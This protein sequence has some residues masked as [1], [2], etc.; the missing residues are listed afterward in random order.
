MNRFNMNN[1]DYRLHDYNFIH[2]KSGR[3]ND[4]LKNVKWVLTIGFSS[5]TIIF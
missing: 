4:G 1:D 5:N 3:I 2:H